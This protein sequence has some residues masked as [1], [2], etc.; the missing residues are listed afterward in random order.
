MLDILRRF[1]VVAV[2]AL[3][4]ALLFVGG[5]VVKAQANEE[6]LSEMKSWAWP[7]DGEIT[8]TFGTRWGNHKGIDIAAPTGTDVVA[9]FDGEVIKSY[10]SGSYG[11]VVFLQHPNGVETVYAH[12]HRRMVEEG[13]K[14]RKGETIGQVGSTGHSTG[15]HLHFE[16][17]MGEWN[18]KKSNAMDPLTVF[19]IQD[20]A[21]PASAMHIENGMNGYSLIKG[22]LVVNQASSEK[23]YIVKKNDTL[24]DIAQ[25]FEVTVS[26]I[27]EWN[28]LSVDVI[29]PDQELIIFEEATYIV[30]SGETM[31]QVAHHLEMSVDELKSL[32]NLIGNMLHPNQILKV[33]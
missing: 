15:P 24:W 19:V 30:Q 14:V 4:I 28:D 7:V 27:M 11:H 3:C 22:E 23:V 20:G 13:A 12:L 33:R 16:V 17:H 9:A 26:S 2:M 6:V 31:E 5:N 1:A 21:L 10:Y 32:N 29:H 18:I 25:Q 8:D